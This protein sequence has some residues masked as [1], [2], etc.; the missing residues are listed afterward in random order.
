MISVYCRFPKVF[1]ECCCLNPIRWVIIFRGSLENGDYFKTGNLAFNLKSFSLSLVTFQLSPLKGPPCLGLLKSQSL[2]VL[3]G[4]GGAWRSSDS[5]FRG[6]SLNRRLTTSNCS[7]REA[8]STGH[9]SGNTTGGGSQNGN[10]NST[11]E[12]RVEHDTCSFNNLMLFIC[13]I[14]WV[15]WMLQTLWDTEGSNHILAV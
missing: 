8:V 1:D 9:N 11:S 10:S 7:L 13:S 2:C 12:E 4:A 14:F 15:S 3:P 5:T 6:E